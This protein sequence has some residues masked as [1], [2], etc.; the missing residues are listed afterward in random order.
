MEKLDELMARRALC[1]AAIKIVDS[2]K[3]DPRRES[4]LKEYNEQ[5]STIDNKIKEITGSYPDIVIGMKPAVIF[6]NANTRS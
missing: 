5:L 4:A 1:I 6:G 2:E 3:N